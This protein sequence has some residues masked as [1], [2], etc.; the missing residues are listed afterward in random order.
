MT[1]EQ[2]GRIIASMFTLSTWPTSQ[3]T[4]AGVTGPPAGPPLLLLHGVLRGWRDFAALWPALLPRWQVHAI[5]HR[6]HG[7]SGRTPGAYRV[8]D[9][10]ADAVELVRDHLPPGVVILG[11]SLGALVAA[12][13]AAALPE[14][15]AGVILEDPPSP[16]FLGHVE[17]T[18]WHTVWT[19]MAPL[20]GSPA[21]TAQVARQ[22][23]EVEQPTAKGP[24][25]LGQLRDAASLRFSAHCLR[26][27]DPGVF[28]PLLASHWLDGWDCAATFRKVRCPALILRGDPQLGGMLERSEAESLC[29]G[30]TEPLLVDVPGVGHL[31]H[32]TAAEAMLRVALPFLESL[33]EL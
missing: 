17:G 8:R 15:I 11:H 21:P 23:A 6:G 9:Y 14:R 18:P 22:L 29:A 33:G 7:G 2:A 16:T 24:M 32:A 5:D 30:M 12:H 13:V 25:R 1:S 10:A 4:L 3:T 31:I 20:A 19:G 26:Q 28:E 27:V